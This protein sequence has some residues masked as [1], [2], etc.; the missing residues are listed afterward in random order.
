MIGLTL[1]TGDFKIDRAFRIAVG[2]MLG[3]VM[4]YQS[5]VLAAPAP[6]LVAGLS[7]PDPWTR[8]AAFNTWNGAGLLL[9]DVMKNTL[10]SCLT[11]GDLTA[12]MGTG[13]VDEKG[14]GVPPDC[15]SIAGQYWDRIIWTIGAWAHYCQNGDREFLATAF[16]AVKNSLP[17]LEKNEY[18]EELK[19]FRGGACIADGLGAYGDTYSHSR[20]SGIY[21]WVEDN[22]DKRHPKGAGLPLMSMSTNCL[23]AESYRLIQRMAEELGRPNDPHWESMRQ[24]VVDGIQTH[25]WDEDGEFFRV[26]HDPWGGSGPHQ[27]C[28]GNCFA[29]LFDV[30]TDEQRARVLENQPHLAY[31]PPAVWPDF[32]RYKAANVPIQTCP[33]GRED[34]EAENLILSQFADIRNGIAGHGGAV[35]GL[36]MGIFGE[37]AL[38][39][40]RRDMF[41]N[42]LHIMAD[43]FC[44]AVQSPEIIHPDCGAPG[45]AVGEVG[46]NPPKIERAV[47]CYRQ[48]WSATSYLRMILHG[49]VGLTPRPDGLTLR[50]YLP[51]G[52]D[53]LSLE[54]LPWR[55]ATLH[56]NIRKTG[57]Q[58]PGVKLDGKLLDNNC[59]P[60]DLRGPHAVDIQIA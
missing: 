18:D 12:G 29:L 35:W 30:A 47:S 41:A 57:D 14:S 56:L 5:G 27:E 21:M 11:R 39:E 52:M 38:R 49:L 20:G 3:N 32:P 45:G 23:Y 50:P 4:S 33:E 46:G 9:P 58:G 1:K 55:E 24:N 25:L 44:R 37:T 43:V 51:E 16:E 54:Y 13:C 34:I 15:L 28:L 48:T 60:P 17:Y 26:Y 7:Y 59:L 19:L 6:C 53:S 31:G 22:P 10:L 2:D 36:M 8:D 42:E 40:G